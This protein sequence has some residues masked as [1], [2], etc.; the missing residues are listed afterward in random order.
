MDVFGPWENSNALVCGALVDLA[1]SLAREQ[2]WARESHVFIY[3]YIY[4]YIYILESRAA[5]RAALILVGW[6]PPP[7]PLRMPGDRKL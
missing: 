3:I 4:I 2:V 5:L 7:K 1:A 6:L